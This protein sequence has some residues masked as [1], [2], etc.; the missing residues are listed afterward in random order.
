MQPRF[1]YPV[2]L[3]FRIAAEVKTLPDKQQKGF[4]ITKTALQEILRGTLKSSKGYKGP[5]T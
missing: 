5:E 3:S 2:R 4:I 1:F